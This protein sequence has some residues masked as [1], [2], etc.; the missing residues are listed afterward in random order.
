MVETIFLSFLFAKIKGYKL[1]SIFLDWPIYIIIVFM[2]TYTYVQIMIFQEAYY[3]LRYQNLF[4]YLYLGSIYILMYRYK[5][6]KE[7][8]FSTIFIFIGSILNVIVMNANGG[9]MP[10]YPSL[11]YYTGYIK[12][13]T[14]Q[15]ADTIHMAGNEFVKMKILTDYID[16]GYTI[17]S[18]GDIFVRIFAFI[19]VFEAIKK[20]SILDT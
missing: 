1:K 5:L 11:S 18:I 16:L 8:I 12:A 17:M 3:V 13:D 14:L 20:K 10:V 6:Y 19:M 7:S 15:K 4:K 2:C 9:K